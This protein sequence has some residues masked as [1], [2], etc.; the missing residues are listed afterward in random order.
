MFERTV[1]NFAFSNISKM[2]HWWLKNFTIL[3]LM[4]GAMM[5]HEK[6]RK[7]KINWWTYITNKNEKIPIHYNF[8]WYVDEYEYEHVKSFLMEREWVP[9]RIFIIIIDAVAALFIT[10]H[11]Y[12]KTIETFLKSIFVW[13]IVLLNSV[14]WG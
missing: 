6:C 1:H 11:C 2:C 7:W 4:K 10:Y 9:S 13:G 14:W 8:C 12:H 5:L 3:L